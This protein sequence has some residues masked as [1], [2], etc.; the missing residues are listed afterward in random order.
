MSSIRVRGCACIIDEVEKAINEWHN[1]GRPS[2]PNLGVTQLFDRVANGNRLKDL[3]PE[4]REVICEMLWAI[5]TI[6]SPETEFM[7]TQLKGKTLSGYAPSFCMKRYNLNWDQ[8][9]VLLH[10]IEYLELTDHGSGQRCP[11]LNNNGAAYLTQHSNLELA[12]STLEWC[13]T[14]EFT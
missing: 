8:A 2:F 4:A 13:L 3:E 11:W 10:T 5:D 12:Q 1:G 14:H 7:K 6:I 9:M